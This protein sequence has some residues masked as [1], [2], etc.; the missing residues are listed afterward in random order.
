[1]VKYNLAVHTQFALAMYIKRHRKRQDFIWSFNFYLAVAERKRYNGSL[2]AVF[3]H[4]KLGF[5]IIQLH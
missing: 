1:M 3:T 2:V 4:H 5:G